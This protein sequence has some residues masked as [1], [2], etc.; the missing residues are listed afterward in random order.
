MASNA[1]NPK[2]HASANCDGDDSETEESGKVPSLPSR[3]RRQSHCLQP[4]RS[5]PVWEGGPITL[6]RN[7]DIV[8]N[9]GQDYL[10]AE[11]MLAWE[12]SKRMTLNLNPLTAMHSGGALRTVGLSANVQLTPS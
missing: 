8:N 10:F 12:A 5:A 1:I 11:T 6:D 3:H 9:T 7:S 4:L 2:K